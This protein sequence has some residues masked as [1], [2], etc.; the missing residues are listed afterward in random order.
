M[1]DEN[2]KGGWSANMAVGGG[3]LVVLLLIW[4]TGA[5]KVK[6]EGDNKG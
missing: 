4:K 5:D 2:G 6:H 3:A 1:T